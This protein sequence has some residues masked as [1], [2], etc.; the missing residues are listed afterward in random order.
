MHATAMQS[1]GDMLQSDSKEKKIDSHCDMIISSSTLR[2]FL[3]PK[4]K[5]TC[6]I[7]VR[8]VV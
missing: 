3:T 4:L 8:Q 6:I 7:C 5:K 1:E 2:G